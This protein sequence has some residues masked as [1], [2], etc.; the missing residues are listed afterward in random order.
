MRKPIYP[1]ARLHYIYE[2]AGVA[3]NI[4]PD[5][6]QVWMTIRDADRSKV[7]AMTEWVRLIAEGAAL[8]AQTRA[9]VDQFYGM[10]DIVPNDTM[11]ALLHQHMTR[12]GLTGPK[13]NRPSRM[14]ASLRWAFRKPVS[15]R[16]S[17]RSRAR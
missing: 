2:N 15:R 1:S 16:R 6:A 13:T 11:I 17:C 5:F 7:E 3:P 14:D 10:Q 9:E 4:V 8:A 12:E